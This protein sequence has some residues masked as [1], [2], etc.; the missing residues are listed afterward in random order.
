MRPLVLLAAALLLAGCTASVPA[1]PTGMSEGIPLTH[2]HVL[3]TCPADEPAHLDA[4]PADIVA[5]HRCEADFHEVQGVLNKVQY[6]QRLV[7]DPAALLSAFT[8]P[9]LPAD[10]GLCATVGHPV[11]QLWIELEDGGILTVRAPVDGCGAA[12]PDAA[13][14]Y[15]AAEFETILVARE[16]ASTLQD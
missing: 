12:L 5:V 6:V 2:P 13:D 1:D 14:L 8:E 9:D 11:R 7:G 10:G 3:L 4:V 16:V 15:D